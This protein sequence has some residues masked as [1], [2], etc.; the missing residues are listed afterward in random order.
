[1]V[2]T[3]KKVYLVLLWTNETNGPHICSS[4]VETSV[5]DS[6][7]ASPFWRTRTKK[8]KHIH[9]RH[10]NRTTFV[11][12]DILGP[13]MKT[14]KGRHRKLGTDMTDR[15]L[16]RLLKKQLC[17]CSNVNYSEFRN[18]WSKILTGK[19][20]LQVFALIIRVPTKHAWACR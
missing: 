1:M 5:M 17:T 16:K 3:D 10:A 19:I 8:K 11:T 4:I 14:K 20:H 2:F 18:K 12:K 15:S 7:N 6:W 9:R 13:L